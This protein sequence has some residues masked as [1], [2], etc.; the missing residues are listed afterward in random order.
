MVLFS[1]DA[2]M[3]NGKRRHAPEFK[4]SV[5][6]EAIRGKFT[7]DEL[8]KKHRVNPSLIHSWKKAV[9]EGAARLIESGSS[10]FWAGGEAGHEKEKQIARLRAENEWLQKIL[11]RLTPNERRAAVEKDN[12][13]LPLLRQVKLLEINRSSVY[14][15][16]GSDTERSPEHKIAN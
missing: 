16:R 12:S 4:A 10:G 13:E 11:L 7:V 15:R 5:A 9:I 3:K 14:Y 2:Y 8:A 1:E 6:L